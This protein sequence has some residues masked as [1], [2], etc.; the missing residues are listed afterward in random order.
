M[1]FSAPSFHV[2]LTY[3]L[4]ALMQKFVG[5]NIQSFK[6][7]LIRMAFHQLIFIG[8]FMFCFFV[9]QNFS[10]TWDKAGLEKGY[11]QAKVKTIETLLTSWQVWPIANII[12][13][14]FVPFKYQLLFTNFVACFWNM[15]MSY[16]TYR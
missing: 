9:Y 2:W 8:P 14:T 4:P 12:N 3:A 13:F 1:T 16:I 7:S 11:T 10:R 15:Y 6:N 5:N